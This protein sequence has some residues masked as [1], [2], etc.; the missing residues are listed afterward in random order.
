MQIA[1]IPANEAARVRMLHS[2][3]LLDTPAE[4][5]FDRATRVL[6]QLL[7]VPIALV[8]LVDTNR[9]WIKSRVGTELSETPRDIAFCAY[10]LESRDMLLIEDALADPRFY[11][12]P[13]VMGEPFLR[14][15]AGVPLSTSTGLVLGTLCALDT[16]PRVL[17]A[18]QKA[19]FVDLARMVER[20]LLQRAVATDVRKVNDEERKA[21]AVVEAHFATVFQQ[22]PTGKALVNLHG[23]FTEVNTKLCELTGY[24]RS[25][26]LNKCFADITHPEDLQGDLSRHAALVEGTRDAYSVEKRYLRQDGSWMWVE[27]N[28]AMVRD[29]QG[30]PLH[31]IADILDISSRKRS[32]AL[33]RE[34]QADLEHRVQART[35]ELHHSRGALQTITDNLPILISHVDRNLRY[36]FNNDVYRQVFGIIPEALIGQRIQ[37]VLA[38]ALFRELEPYFRRALAG[39][40][41]V[42]EQ[43]RYEGTGDRV[44]AATYIPDMRDGE[45]HGFFVMSQDVTERSQME[46]SLRDEAMRDSLTG[47]PNRRAFNEML[48]QSTL[49]G[50]QAFALLFLDMDGFKGVNDA[51]GHDIGDGLLKEVAARLQRTVRK[52]DFACRLAGDEFV[53][54]AHGVNSPEI[55]KRIAHNLCAAMARPFVISGITLKV[56]ASI[57][58][59]LCPEGGDVSPETLVGQADAAMYDAKRQGRSGYR[60]AGD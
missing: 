50:A 36:L 16:S 54:V 17:S 58:V 34:H 41:V 19:A 46:R 56:G 49:V 25:A 10:A 37:D 39:E 24:S 20:E 30:R 3:A 23:Q 59:T 52:A 40:R 29:D 7:Q 6:A 60:L 35:A 32:E 33:L 14:F 27:V 18:A 38:P 21:R 5:C 48:K 12:N 26:L 53:V 44:W 4:E 42:H 28:V 51:H 2:L 57:G 8:S 45:V 9:Q 13:L 55:A 31:C 43:V 47:L 15:Y 11:K 1:P 22:A